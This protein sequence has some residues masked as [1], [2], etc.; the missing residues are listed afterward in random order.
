MQFGRGCPLW[1]RVCP[2]LALT[3]ACL[4]P[5]LSR[6]W[7]DLQ[8]ASSSLVF[9]QSF[10]P[11]AAQQCLRLGLFTGYFSLFFFFFFCL[12]LA[13]PQFRLLS[14][15]SSLRLPSGHSGLVLTLSN[16][17]CSSLF[18]LCLLVVDASIWATSLL[19]VT[20]RH[21]ICEFHLF[22]FPHGYVALQDSKT[23]PRPSSEKVSWFLET[24]PLLRLPSWN[25]S[26]SL[27]R[28]SLF[29]SFICCP[30]SF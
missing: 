2:F 7:A 9:A 16:A 26:P 28:L 27:T 5:A 12:S 17:A 11:C 14:H 29:L 20:F 24:S 18:T 13:I 6:R 30:T 8:P 23:F 1:G 4:A 19:G 21:I 25:G 15:I 22:I 10:V 3:G